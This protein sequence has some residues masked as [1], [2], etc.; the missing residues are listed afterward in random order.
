MMADAPQLLPCPRCTELLLPDTTLCT[1]CGYDMTTG[2]SRRTDSEE[3]ADDEKQYAGIARWRWQLLRFESFKDRDI[4]LALLLASLGFILTAH[5]STKGFV[6][7]G[8]LC[9]GTAFWM[10]VDVSWMW[11]ACS[12]LELFLGRDLG[13][14]WQQILKLAAV[15]AAVLALH[16]CL[17]WWVPEVGSVVAFWVTPVL[18]GALL[19]WFLE[20][21]LISA[22]VL[23]V[24]SSVGAGIA[25]AVA[26]G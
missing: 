4:P 17:E 21:G 9:K 13:V 7:L 5:I 1:H 12:L 20:L 11:A 22:V 8:Q 26:F 18:T 6:E 10:A 15:A 24:V 19:M 3:F 2:F 14:W 23:L 25:F 16:V